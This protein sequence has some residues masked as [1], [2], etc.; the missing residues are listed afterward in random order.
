LTG[1]ISTLVLVLLFGGSNAS[2]AAPPR[3]QLDVNHKKQLQTFRPYNIAHR[4]SNGELPEET[5]AAYL[6]TSL[7]QYWNKSPPS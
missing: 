1:H 5:S 7:E 4:G 2:T 6:V 3:S